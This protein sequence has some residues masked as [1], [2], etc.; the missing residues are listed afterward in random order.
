MPKRTPVIP[1]GVEINGDRLRELRKLRGETL[2]EFAPRCG[3]SFGYLSQIERRHRPRVSP[4]T[5]V[6]ICDA[7]GVPDT[8]RVSM[9]VPE[10]RRRMKAAA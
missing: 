7:L 3:I 8:D 5:F 4:H 1:A 10:V 2:E 6:A 9:V